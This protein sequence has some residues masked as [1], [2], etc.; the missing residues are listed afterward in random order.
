MKC[1][2]CQA[3]NADNQVFC[4]QCGAKLEK[5]C[6]DCG[7]SNPVRYR[8]CGKCSHELSVTNGKSRSAKDGKKKR[9]ILRNFFIAFA[10]VFAVIA[11]GIVLA[12][13]VLP[14]YQNATTV[15]APVQVP[16]SPSAPSNVSGQ[17]NSRSQITIYWVDTSY[18][19][20]GFRIYR[21]GTFVGSV[22]SN[23][24]AFQDTG[25]Q[26]GTKYAYSVAAYNGV[27]EARS[28]ATIQVKTLNPP[29]VVTLDKIGVIFD[30]DPFPKGA[31]EIY[32]LLAVSDGEGEPVTIR[33]PSNGY[34][35]LND[36]ETID[37]GE[38][39]FSS[40]CV[41]DEL[42]IVGVAFE[43]DDPIFEGIVNIAGQVLFSKIGGAASSILTTIFSQGQP[44]ED[45]SALLGLRESSADDLVGA[46]E[47]TY[48]SSEKWGLGSYEVVTSGDLM[49]W[50]TISMPK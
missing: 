1:L 25:L 17:A 2:K 18:N 26:Y 4:G 34:I 10:C 28:A 19:E 33:V 23:V 42:R 50:F 15:Y 12:N 16:Q 37:L 7:T 8:Y 36:N 35:S 46:I 40:Y 45:N 14:A 32:L 13:T 44:T 30:H 6:P 3:D 38:Q 21:N 9:H 48:T 43:S 11:I 31:G 49:L 24:T 22:G 47:K 29:I 39:I 41:G 27:G 20:D 5:I